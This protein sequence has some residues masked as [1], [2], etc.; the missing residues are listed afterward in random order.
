LVS[1]AGLQAGEVIADK[2]AVVEA[3]GVGGS[4]TVYRARRVGMA[5]EVALKVMHAEHP[6]GDNERQRFAREAELVMKL[7][8]AHVVPLLD[9]GHTAEGV[10]FLVFA[11]LQ[12][13]SLERRIKTQGS[14]AWA[15]AGR[16]SVQ[17]LRAL[18]KAHGLGVVHRDIKPANIFLSTGVFGEVA[19]VLD[20]GLAKMVRDE[21][22]SD[23]T[24][25]GALLGTPRYM[26]PEQ[27]RGEQ[28]T[29]AAD[30]YSFGLVMA[31][32]LLGRPLIAGEKELDIYVAQGSDK[33]IFLPDEVLTTPFGAIIQRAVSKPVAVRYSMASQM[34]ADV[35]AA[36]AHLEAPP[37]DVEADLEATRM[38][39]PSLV[40]KIVNPHAEKMRRVLN[41][42]AN[43]AER[44]KAKATPTPASSPASSDPPAARPSAPRMPAVQPPGAP[45]MAMPATV[46][47][48]AP[49]RPSHPT[50]FEAAPTVA[51]ADPSSEVAMA[52]SSALAAANP[53]AATAPPPSGWPQPA[54]QPR[55]AAPYGPTQAFP[56]LAPAY[57]AQPVAPTQALAPT[58]GLAP[59][60]ALASPRESLPAEPPLLEPAGIAAVPPTVTGAPR[61]QTG[62]AIALVLVIALILAGVAA[63]LWLLGLLAL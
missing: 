22:P 34:L 52:R 40:P 16:F 60:Q 51:A 44:D 45:T 31:E 43:K 18:E 55:A 50:P 47:A 6:D 19:Q 4:A 38:L 28:I 24:Q 10:P 54:A 35:E 9:Y 39:D 62:L 36:L 12:G 63:L 20:F 7:Q 56:A 15:T 26:A 14:L 48:A 49:P 37:Q 11:L 17:V 46:A 27:V 32:M 61:S 2:Y 23:L 8:H 33:P 13:Q 57:G 41:A 21:A 53:P 58:Q 30:I 59:T 1:E 25:A 29:H 42:A 3:I 5:H